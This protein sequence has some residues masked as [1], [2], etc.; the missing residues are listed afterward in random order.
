MRDL[1]YNWSFGRNANGPPI[2]RLLKGPDPKNSRYEP[3]YL[4]QLINESGLGIIFQ[5][6][7]INLLFIIQNMYLN[8]LLISIT[9]HG[10]E[11]Q[12]SLQR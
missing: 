1:E 9:I 2:T 10:S 3:G 12:K 4:T 8:K 11:I 5:V 7:C 6:V